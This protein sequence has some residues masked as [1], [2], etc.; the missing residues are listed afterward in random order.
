[1]L[2]QPFLHTVLTWTTF[3]LCFYQNE[4]HLWTEF[5]QHENMTECPNTPGV[6]H[7]FFMIW[8]TLLLGNE[9][10]HGQ[11]NCTL[12]KMCKGCC[13]LYCWL[14]CS[15]NGLHAI[16]WNIYKIFMFLIISNI[17]TQLVFQFTLYLMIF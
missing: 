13:S 3:A 5:Q 14:K 2:N 1:M 10:H 11:V 9:S 12:I 6:H 15:V 7:P 8:L 16:M 4:I 17:F